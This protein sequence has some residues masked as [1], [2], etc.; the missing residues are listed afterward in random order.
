MA[1]SLIAGLITLLEVIFVAG[2]AGS[3][4]VIILTSIEDVREVFHKDTAE[5][6]ELSSIGADQP[7]S[8]ALGPAG[9]SSPIGA[10]R[11]LR[12]R[13]SVLPPAQLRAGSPA[14]RL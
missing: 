14:Q 9:R 1:H 2:V 6:G 11:S 8:E 10:A 12:P 3:A 5:D 13:A 7:L 4:I